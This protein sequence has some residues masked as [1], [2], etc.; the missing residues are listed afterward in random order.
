MLCIRAHDLCTHFCM[1]CVCV[2]V[3]V[4]G[5][6]T[7][8]LIGK[9]MTYY[10]E[11]LRKCVSSFIPHCITSNVCDW[12]KGRSV[13]WDITHTFLNRKRQPTLFV[14]V[15]NCTLKTA[16]AC[17]GRKL[18]RL[19]SSWVRCLASSALPGITENP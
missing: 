9:C 2:C 19:A 8:L 12:S 3:C 1:Y 18:D 11:I 10:H 14:S 5:I 7:E 17:M 16:H 15:S 13:K 6:P 4:C